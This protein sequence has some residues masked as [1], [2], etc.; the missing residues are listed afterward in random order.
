MP[1]SWPKPQAS[2]ICCIFCTGAFGDF[3][4]LA[5]TLSLRYMS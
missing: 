2:S 3:T 1:V 4:E 5:F